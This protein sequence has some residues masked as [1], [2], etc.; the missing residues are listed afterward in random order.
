MRVLSFLY[1]FRGIS[2]AWL[3]RLLDMQKVTGPSPVSPTIFPHVV[4][5]VKKVT[6]QGV[7]FFSFTYTASLLETIK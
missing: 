4:L 3:E 5:V 6:S 1:S 7:A 2:S